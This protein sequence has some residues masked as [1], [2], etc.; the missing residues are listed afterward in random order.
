MNITTYILKNF[1]KR[2]F[3]KILLIIIISFIIN[4]FQIN[5]LSYIVANI[6]NNI[7]K[8]NKKEIYKYSKYFLIISFIYVLIY[9]YYKFL[10]NT[11]ITNLRQDS[12]NLLIEMIVT[13][14]NNKFENENFI[15]LN[16]PI[17]R[18]SS[19][20]FLIF[21]NFITFILPNITLFLII[22]IYFFYIDYLF[23]FIFLSGNIIII[24]YLFYIFNKII[25]YNNIYED[26]VKI[27]DNN[28]VEIL[29]NID[30]IIYRNEYKNEL[31]LFN[32]DGKKLKKSSYNFYDITNKYSIIINIILYVLIGIVLYYLISLFLNK[33]LN[34]TIFITIITIV[35]LYRDRLTTIIQQLPDYI[36]FIGKSNSVIDQ[37][38]NYPEKYE[39]IILKNYKIFKLKFDTITVKNL[40]FK[41]KNTDKD[42]FSNLN[43]KINLNDKI[44]GIIGKSGQGKS[45]LAK[46]IIKTYYYEGIIN[47]DDIDINKIDTSYIRNNILYVDQNLKLFDRKIID[48]IV[49]SCKN[50]DL[51]LSKISNIFK[52]N[53]IS[54]LYKKINLDNLAG[55]NGEKLS[56]GQRQ[57]INIINALILDH[58]ILI[59]DEPT[60]ALDN[61]L[62]REIIELISEYK[63][64]KKCIII[65][66]HDK[67]IMEICNKK[68]SI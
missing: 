67:D 43:L 16:S 64:Y 37:F 11:L 4:I 41:Y 53:K 61:D 49:Y 13:I 5:I 32:Q 35:L 60:N 52:Y 63:K 27:N 25:V 23:G 47:I 29:N 33:K 9:N 18:I 45:T 15:K 19:I 1:F 28:T 36:E 7:N 62:K 17:N 31:K 20:L 26:D 44:I 34:S 21:N 6:I 46:L 65:I 8:N 40:Y 24:I 68:I 2:D 14:N 48:N 50:K 54:E 59:L 30:K 12:K 57:V 58:Q 10:Q 39:D 55:L 22:S 42:I 51:C 56:G 66:S 38:K 3:Y